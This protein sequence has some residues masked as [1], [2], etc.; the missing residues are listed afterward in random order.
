[1]KRVER[2]FS[3][4]LF[5]CVL[6]ERKARMSNLAGEFRVNDFIWDQ[7]VRR[8]RRGAT[9]R[10]GGRSVCNGLKE[11]NQ[12]PLW[13]RLDKEGLRSPKRMFF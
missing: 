4:A 11:F 13:I 6:G 3:T 9:R 1:M 7:E 2:W 10:E 5:V 12:T 8:P